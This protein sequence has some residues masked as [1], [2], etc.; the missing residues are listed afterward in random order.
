MTT[1]DDSPA[2]PELELAEPSPLLVLALQ[3][4]DE[5]HT[6]NLEQLLD[7]EAKARGFTRAAGWQWNG[8]SWQHPKPEAPHVP[9]AATPPAPALGG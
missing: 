2:P 7:A 4:L 5:L 9:P 8:R 1:P 6:M 3:H